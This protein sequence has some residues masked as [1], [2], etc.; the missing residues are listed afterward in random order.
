MKSIPNKNH[1][2]GHDNYSLWVE[3]F[4]FISN[5]VHFNNTPDTLR[6]TFFISSFFNAFN[7][8]F[9]ATEYINNSDFLSIY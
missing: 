1:G 5:S 7:K 6:N 4:L 3:S 9:Q 8:F 2:K